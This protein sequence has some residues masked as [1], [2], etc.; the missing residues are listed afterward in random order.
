MFIGKIA[1][2]INSLIEEYTIYILLP[3]TV[4]LYAPI[5]CISYLVVSSSAIFDF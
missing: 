3:H 5:I 1:K 2:Y 4:Y